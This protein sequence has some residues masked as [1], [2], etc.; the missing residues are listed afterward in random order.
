M[1]WDKQRDGLE[2]LFNEAQASDHDPRLFG[3]HVCDRYCRH[4]DAA[5]VHLMFLDL[6]FTLVAQTLFGAPQ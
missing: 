5:K 1:A 2:R 6:C 4:S 3:T